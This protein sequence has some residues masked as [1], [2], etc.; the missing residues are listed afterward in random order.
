MRESATRL[1]ESLRTQRDLYAQMLAQIE[2]V[3]DRAAA[4]PEALM[5]LLA[6]Q[7]VIKTQIETLQKE[8]AVQ[9]QAIEA[10]AAGP[11][12]EE[13]RAIDDAVGEVQD[14]LRR[15]IKAQGD[16]LSRWQAQRDGV[17]D[18]I[19]HLSQG[20]RAIDAYAGQRGGRRPPRE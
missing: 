3:G 5:A 7:R 11:S 6:E 8:A 10:D 18:R 12:E 1:L 4:D 2:A 17:V 20:R 9:R 16:G 19:R 15:L 14:L 13:R